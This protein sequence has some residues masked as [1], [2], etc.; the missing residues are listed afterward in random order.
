MDTR[1]CDQD[2]VVD[3][4]LAIGLYSSSQGAERFMFL[5]VYC[6]ILAVAWL[7]GIV[8]SVLAIRWSFLSVRGRFWPAVILSLAS[9]A[10]AYYGITRFNFNSTTTVNGQVK[11]RFDSRWPFMASL[12]LGT[13]A[14]V[15]TI[16]KKTKSAYLDP[17]TDR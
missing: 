15:C 7:A 12:V 16:W 17:A 5:Y 8:A 11:W 2:R 6:G 4:E 10:I 13:F 1:P 3:I 14:L 9:L